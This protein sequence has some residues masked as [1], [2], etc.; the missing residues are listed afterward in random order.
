MRDRG[1]V[2]SLPKKKQRL[3]SEERRLR[4]LTAA[5]PLFAREGFRG[6]TTKMLAREAEVSE[7]LLYQHFPSKEALYLQVEILCCRA[8]AELERQFIGLE[9]STET[10]V[11]LLF[12]LAQVIVE[13][14]AVESLDG[15]FPRLLVHSVLEDGAFARAHM[16]RNLA[17]MAHMVC[18]SVT[19]AREHGDLV[20]DEMPNDLRFWF[21]QHL[22]GMVHLFRMSERPVIDYSVQ[23]PALTDAAMRFILRG[24]GLTAAATSRHYDYERLGAKVAPWLACLT[25]G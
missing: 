8:N 20:A 21:S 23:G 19:A 7:A 24:V 9:P 4:I 17:P 12:F 18:Q 11:A 16:T 5:I 10:L 1:T 15:L 22:L 13:N 2:R 14:K 6:V 3:S 25:K